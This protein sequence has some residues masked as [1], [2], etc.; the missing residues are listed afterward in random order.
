MKEDLFLSIA[1]T[2]AV[3]LRW[4]VANAESSIENKTVWATANIDDTW[5]R[6]ALNV[7]VGIIA[8]RMQVFT[9]VDIIVA[10]HVTGF[11]LNI[12]KPLII[13]S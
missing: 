5:C 3:V 4:I 9:L 6:V 10:A 11:F 12:N 1:V 13:L 7:T 8:V 2:I